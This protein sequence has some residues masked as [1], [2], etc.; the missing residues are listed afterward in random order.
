M[1]GAAGACFLGKEDREGDPSKLGEGFKGLILT[2]RGVLG[3]GILRS[4]DSLELGAGREQDS[5]KSGW[6]K[7]CGRASFLLF[8]DILRFLLQ[9]KL[10]DLLACVGLVG[11]LWSAVLGAGEGIS[12]SVSFTHALLLLRAFLSFLGMGSLGLGNIIGVEALEG[13]S[14]GQFISGTALG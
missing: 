1:L 5:S 4:G 6:G 9:G 7:G 2:C 14:S 12:Q 10:E 13:S 11:G 3:A 8:L